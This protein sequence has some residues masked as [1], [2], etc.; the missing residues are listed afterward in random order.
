MNNIAEV[1]KA[2]LCTGC[3][4]CVGVCSSEAIK[5]YIQDGLLLPHVNTSKCINC[6]ICVRCCPGYSVDLTLLKTELSVSEHEDSFLGSFLNC[7]VGH[8]GSKETRGRSSSGGIVTQLLLYA[9]RKGV[10]DGALVVGWSSND[11]FEPQALIARSEAEILSSSGS[12]Y[13]PVAAVSSLS[14]ILSQRGKFA[15]VGLPCHIHGIRKAERVFRELED[16]IVLHI[17]L[18]CGHTVNFNG[19]QVILRKLGLKKGS[20]KHIDYRSGGWPGYFSVQLENG[21]VLKIRYNGGWNAYWNVFS[22]MLFT[23]LR[24]FMCPDQCNELADISTGDAWLPELKGESQ[25]ESIL[26]ARTKPGSMILSEMQQNNLLSLR[27]VPLSKVKESQ[28][29]NLNFKK[30]NLFARIALLKML[31]RNQPRITPAPSPFSMLA[32]LTSLLPYLSYRVSSSRYLQRFFPYV[33]L[34]LFRILFIPFKA[35]SI[36]TK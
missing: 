14:S 17:G 22:P 32:F 36:L 9:L 31:G 11:P 5:M 26:I 20:I 27:E 12:K 4:T 16:R 8:G 24:C 15:V 2:G 1:V 19:T 21:Q 13:C 35:I 25:G 3:G 23:P 30:K 28:A 10:I 7:Y 6:R 18:F 33:P 34:S 29:F